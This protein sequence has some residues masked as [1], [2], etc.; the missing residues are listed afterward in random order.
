MKKQT[1]HPWQL[2]VN[3]SDASNLDTAFSLEPDIAIEAEPSL[4]ALHA[5]IGVIAAS[6]ATSGR[7]CRVKSQV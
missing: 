3:Y 2:T 5:D 7:R 6:P 1:R 4:V